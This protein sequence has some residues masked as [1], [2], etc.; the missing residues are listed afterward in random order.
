MKPRTLSFLLPL[1]CAIAP[2]PAVAVDAT[3]GASTATTAP[4][5]VERERQQIRDRTAKVLDALYAHHPDARQ[6]L[7]DATGYAVFHNFGMKILV[8]GGGAGK[9]VAVDNRDHRETFMRM[10]EIQAGLGVGAKQFD[11]I[12]VFKTPKAYDDFIRNGFELTGEAVAAARAYDKGGSL[13]GAI[14]VS[15]GVWLYQ[16]TE[17]GLAAEITVKGTRYYL[18]KELN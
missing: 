10:A 14:E 1:L 15:P 13:G 11:L 9:G 7:R 16:M 17:N 3:P 6:V 8:A 12:W 5:K 18:D 4:D 2:W